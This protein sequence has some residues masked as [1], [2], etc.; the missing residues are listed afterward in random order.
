MTS[1]LFGVCQR[2]IAPNVSKKNKKK[3]QSQTPNE[4][5]HVLNEVLS[6]TIQNLQNLHK[7]F[8]TYEQIIVKEVKDEVLVEKLSSMSLNTENQDIEELRSLIEQSY[9]KTFLNLKNVANI[10]LNYLKLLRS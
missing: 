5:M 10:K 4:N 3:P 2:L 6:K 8:N 7:F 1:I 9:I